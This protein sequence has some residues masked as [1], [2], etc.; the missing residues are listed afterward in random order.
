MN[1]ENEILEGHEINVSTEVTST[2]KRIVKILALPFFMFVDSIML[3][4]LL[5][6]AILTL[7]LF[8]F[9]ETCYER[10]VKTVINSYYP[11]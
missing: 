9:T 8:P 1:N 2:G 3:L 11:F 10:N 7:A 6:I 4:W 5:G